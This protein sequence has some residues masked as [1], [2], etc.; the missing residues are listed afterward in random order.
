MRKRFEEY[1]ERVYPGMRLDGPTATAEW[2]TWQAAFMEGQ[3]HQ[4]NVS[5]GIREQ[6]T[7]P[8]R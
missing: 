4:I 7:V 8:C 2:N 1:F 5:M 3:I 6:E